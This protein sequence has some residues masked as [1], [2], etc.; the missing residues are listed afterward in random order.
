MA[1]P[2]HL[3]TVAVTQMASTAL[4]RTIFRSEAR[5][6]AAMTNVDFIGNMQMQGLLDSDNGCAHL[7]TQ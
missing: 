7:S 2:I 6:A 5:R 3:S 1:Q 4:R